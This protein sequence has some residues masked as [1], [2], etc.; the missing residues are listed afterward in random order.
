MEKIPKKLRPFLDQS[1]K[2][3]YRLGALLA[4]LGIIII[5]IP[6]P[7]LMSI[8]SLIESSDEDEKRRVYKDQADAMATFVVESQNL[9]LERLSGK[10]A[11]IGPFNHAL[12]S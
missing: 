10:N 1:Q 5:P 8:N 7:C 9:T 12:F 6:F 11:V 2:Y 3:K 4:F